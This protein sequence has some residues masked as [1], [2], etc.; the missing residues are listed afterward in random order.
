MRLRNV[1]ESVE[2]LHRSPYFVADP[3]AQ[4]GQWNKVF[5]N[6]NPIFVEAGTGKGQ[7]LVEMARLHPD[8]NFIGIEL[9]ES[10]L[11]KATKRLDAMQADGSADSEHEAGASEGADSAGTMALSNLRLICEDVRHLPEIFDKGEIA[12]LYIN[13]SDPWPKMRHAKRRLTAPGFLALYE[14]TLAPGGRLE[15]KTDSVPLFSYSTE[16]IGE[17]DAWELLKKT[18]DLHADEAM[19]AD[20]CLT[21]YEER[22]VAEGKPICKLIAR[23]LILLAAVV[24]AWGVNPLPALAEEMW[25]AGIDT[26]SA[27]M[28]VVE[29][30][31]G[32]VL[33]QKAPNKENY[34]ASITKIM[35]ALLAI[36]NCDMDEVVTFS[37]DA[38]RLNEGDTSHISR[39][40]GEKMTMEECLY[41]MMLESANECAWAIAE[42]VGGDCKSFVRMMNEKADELGCRHTH[43]ANPNGLPQDNHYTSCAD[44]AKIAREAFKNKTFRTIVGTRSY[45][46][47][48]TNTHSVETPLNNHHAMLNFYKTDDYLYEG[49]LGGKTGY[50]DAAQYTLVTY[51]RRNGMTLVCVVMNA[52]SPGFYTDTIH[53]FDYCFSNFLTYSVAETGGLTGAAKRGTG[54]LM[55]S[56]EMFRVDEDA[57]VVLPKTASVLNTVPKVLPL[58]KPQKD[59]VGDLE[60][61]YGD[62]FV[63]GGKLM[64]LPSDDGYAY[65]FQNQMESQVS[66]DASYIYIDLFFIGRCLLIAVG[67]LGVVMLIKLISPALYQKRM[68]RR[69]ELEEKKPKYK[70]IRNNGRKRR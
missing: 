57:S 47:P 56:S 70:L 55:D 2:I 37:E 15:F 51:A 64:F 31:S 54:I 9:Y 20:N 6:N 42:H 65:H 32:A 4:K 16:T 62:H 38:V 50:T 18:T 8:T 27:S 68:R 58:E 3:F 12:R 41:G 45:S 26:E 11:Y 30:D 36:E 35:T 43:F 25:P 60:F 29:E 13:F 5:Q 33:L 24:L 69:I 63:G 59:V 7:F 61:Y 1:P 34:P 46:I 10:V 49:C 66:D 53:L 52:P 44:M 67:V 28:I 14:Q 22:F 40:I 39:D 19:R 48:P 21:E 23:L 17:A